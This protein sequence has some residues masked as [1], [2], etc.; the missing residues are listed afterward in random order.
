MESQ[1]RM[2]Y[3]ARICVCEEQE[4]GVNM[5]RDALVLGIGWYLHNSFMGERTAC[6]IQSAHQV[7]YLDLFLEITQIRAHPHCK[8]TYACN[9]APASEVSYRR[10]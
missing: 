5:F 4:I 9:D 2:K 1:L 6:S 3:L 8:Y 7:I 10:T